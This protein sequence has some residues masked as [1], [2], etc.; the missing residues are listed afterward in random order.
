[1]ERTVRNIPL[2]GETRHL[3]TIKDDPSYGPDVQTRQFAFL[4]DLVVNGVFNKLLH[5][6]PVPFDVFR[7][8]HDGQCWVVE[9]EALER[10]N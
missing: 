3:V 4:Q 6:G 8:Y 5:C 7:M 9:M 10:K 1:M 2:D